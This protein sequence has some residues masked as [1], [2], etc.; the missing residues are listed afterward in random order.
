MDQLDH[1]REIVLE[2]LRGLVGGDVRC[3][4]LFLQLYASDGSI[5]EIT[6]LGVVHPRSAADVAACVEYAANKCIPIHARGAGTG[7]AG[8]CLGPGLVV[9]TSR[10]LRHVIRTGP[11]WVRV[12]P[13]IVHE[14]L[15]HHLRAMGRSFSPDPLSSPVTTVGSMIAVD[16]AGS[17]PA[18]GSRSGTFA[19]RRPR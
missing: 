14:R 12:Q 18:D 2:D 9:D 1:Q 7:L 11:D 15:N 3:D 19:G 5:Y 13:G 16:A 8:G 17:R 4:N 6:P 10:F